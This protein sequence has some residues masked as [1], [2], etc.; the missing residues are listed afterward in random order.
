MLRLVLGMAGDGAMVL[1]VLMWLAVLYIAGVVVWR[2]YVAT[3]LAIGGY[4]ESG[5]GG[6]VQYA[7]INLLISL[8][9]LGKFAFGILIVILIVR[10]CAH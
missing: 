6:A 3:T 1:T 7:I 9:D 8:W 10:G 5:W 2:L 4:K